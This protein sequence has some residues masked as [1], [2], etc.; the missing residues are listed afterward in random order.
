MGS[1]PRAVATGSKTQVDRSLLFI[2]TRRSSRHPVHVTGRPLHR[3]RS[4]LK[5]TTESECTMKRNYDF[6]KGVKNAYLK[7]IIVSVRIENGRDVSKSLTCNAIVD[8]SASLMIL[9]VAWKD[10]LGDLDSSR[11]I[12]VDTAKQGTINAEV[13]GPVRIQIEGFRPIY[14]EVSFAENTGESEPLIGHIVLTQSQAAVDML[15]HRLVPIIYM[16]LKQVSSRT[17]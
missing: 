6:S 10:R 14:S 11:T 2:A 12:E 1:V 5:L 4:A 3:A 7:R 8:T 9:P 17:P 13:C 16:D 15:G